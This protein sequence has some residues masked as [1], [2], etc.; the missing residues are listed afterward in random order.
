MAKAKKRK[1]TN[2]IRHY[3]DS[4]IRNI[5]ADA[6]SACYRLFMAV[7][8]TVALDKHDAAPWIADYVKEMNDMIGELNADRITV[9][10][11]AQVLDEEYDILLDYKQIQ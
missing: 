9:D 1:K 5:Q 11:L 4:D 3:R 7:A 6:V 10:E 8:L 2:P